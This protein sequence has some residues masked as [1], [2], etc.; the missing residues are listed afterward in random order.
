MDQQM[1]LAE[2]DTLDA[3]GLPASLPPSL[4]SSA[5]PKMREWSDPEL[6]FMAEIERFELTAPVSSDDRR[7]GIRVLEKSLAGAPKA[8]IGAELTR[9]HALTKARAE[10]QG[11]IKM[12]VAAFTAELSVYPPTA[13]TAVCREWSRRSKFWPSWAELYAELEDAVRPRRLLLAALRE[14]DGETA[15]GV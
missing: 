15:A 11:D 10:E 8:V 9:L 7:R 3:R 4:K 14:Q 12:K 1:A 5:K 13:V 2:T 6:G